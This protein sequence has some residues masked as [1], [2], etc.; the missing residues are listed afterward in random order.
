MA[1]ARRIDAREFQKAH[2]SGALPRVRLKQLQHARIIGVRL[3]GQG[4]GDE[5]GD[6]IVAH[7]HGVRVPERGTAGLRGRPGT[8][9]RD[10]P[11]PRLRL[12]RGHRHGLFQTARQSPDPP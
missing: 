11:K 8:D 7:A 9:A 10:R 5:R 2:H 6:V 3:A 4:P 12:G 1:T